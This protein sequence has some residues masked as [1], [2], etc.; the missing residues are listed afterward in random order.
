MVLVAIG[1]AGFCVVV[2]GIYRMRRA[3]E[4]RRL[5]ERSI[6]PEAL[7]ALLKEQEDFLVFDVRQPL[8]LLAHSEILPGARRIPPKELLEHTS[9]LPKDQDSVV[10][11]TCP[12]EKTS[13]MILRRALALG[14]TRVKFLKGGFEGW[15][16]KGFPVEPYTISFRLDTAV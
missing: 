2:F 11:C 8:D 3:A 14:F 10:Y 13:R 1:V 4:R 15:K 6:E 12:G 5:E 9:L 16:A 7:L